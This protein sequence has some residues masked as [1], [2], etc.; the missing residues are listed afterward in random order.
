M[1]AVIAYP[2]LGLAYLVSRL[3]GVIEGVF[4]IGFTVMVVV[5]LAERTAGLHARLVLGTT[6]RPAGSAPQLPWR[7]GVAASKPWR[8]G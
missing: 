1:G 5:Q 8:S 3:G 4:F 7:G 2:L 6:E